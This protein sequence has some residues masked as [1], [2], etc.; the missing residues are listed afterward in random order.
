[1]IRS[2]RLAL[3]T[4]AIGTLAAGTAAAQDTTAVKAGMADKPSF[5]TFV[6]AVN[7]TPATVEALKTRPAITSNEV[8]LVNARELT[9]GQN[10]STVTAA[11]ESHRADIGQLQTV[12][13]GHAEVKAML[14]KQAPGAEI[15]AAEVQPTGKI[16]VFYWTKSE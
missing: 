13:G 10:D 9:Q 16:V 7:S 6:G 11:L 4:L 2:L 5:E 14:E 3:A 15:V 12:L 8:V 1:M